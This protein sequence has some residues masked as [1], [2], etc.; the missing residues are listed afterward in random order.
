MSFQQGLSGLNAAAKNLDAIGNNVANSNTVGY[1]QARAEFADV[2]ASVNGGGAQIGIGAAV[3]AV[4]QQFNQGNIITTSNP[5]DMAVKGAGFFRMSQNGAISYTRNGQFA[6]DKDGYI[7]SNAGARLTGF[8]VDSQGKIVNS[9]VRELKMNLGSIDPRATNSV[10]VGANLDAGAT[11]ISAAF[12]AADPTTFNSSTAITVYDEPGNAHTLTMYMAKDPAPATDQ[13]KLYAAIDGTKIGNTAIGTL[14]F[15]AGGV[16][17]SGSPMNVT[18]TGLGSVAG[19]VAFPIAF[20]SCTQFG[21]PFGIN[22]MSQDGYATGRLNGFAVDDTGAILG[23]YTNGQ[24]RVLGE[25]VLSNFTNPQGLLALGDGQFSE[26]STSGP[27]LTGQPGSGSLGAVQSGALEESN[28]DLTEELVNMITAQRAYQANAQ[29]IR[30]Q[31]QLL[32]TI[33]NLR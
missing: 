6:L 32:Q 29:T 18:L 15:S 1:K 8:P 25:I 31:D 19:T 5:L 16:L 4:K 33:V 30:T 23:R 9:T 26:T 14:K 7:V 12:D 11:P 28:V 20:D 27:P 3:V 21:A 13:W 2:F 24:S 17:Q 22:Q 10:S